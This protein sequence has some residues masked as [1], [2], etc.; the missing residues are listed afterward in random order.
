MTVAV[1]E[2]NIVE[3]FQY[4]EDSFRGF[5]IFLISLSIVLL[6]LIM[7]KFL[8]GV[9][10]CL[11]MIFKDSVSFFLFRTLLYNLTFFTE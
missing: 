6:F 2:D 10:T 7:A 9:M 4:L 1:K 8:L 3:R 5:N 11:D